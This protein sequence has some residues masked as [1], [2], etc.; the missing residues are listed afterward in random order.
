[1]CLCVCWR[2]F[3]RVKNIIRIVLVV[4]GVVEHFLE[5]YLLLARRKKSQLLFFFSLF[6]SVLS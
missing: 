5:L 6:L 1:M 3:L 2:G 4:V